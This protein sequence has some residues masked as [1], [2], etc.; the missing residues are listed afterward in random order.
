MKYVIEW[1]APRAA[2]LL[3]LQTV[4][5]C[6]IRTGWIEPGS[7][8]ETNLALAEERLE[9]VRTWNPRDQ[10]RLGE[11][12]D[13]PYC[14]K[15]RVWHLGTCEEWERGINEERSRGEIP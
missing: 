3:D 2:S 14:I 5:N 7:P 15:H 6:W 12:D 9:E 10:Y 8:A 4:G 1:Y 11:K 13:V